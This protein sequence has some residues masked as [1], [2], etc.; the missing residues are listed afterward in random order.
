MSK[1]ALTNVLRISYG[2]FESAVRGQNFESFKTLAPISR[3]TEELQKVTTEYKIQLRASRT[4]YVSATNAK[5]YQFVAIRGSS[6]RSVIPPLDIT[7][8]LV[9]L[10]LFLLSTQPLCR[11]AQWPSC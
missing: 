4:D 11:G 9:D 5:L 6:G 1:N 3:L 10:I 7:Y 2:R 8:K